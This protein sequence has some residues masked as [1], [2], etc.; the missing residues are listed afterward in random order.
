MRILSEQLELPIGIMEKEGFSDLFRGKNTSVSRLSIFCLKQLFEIF[1][2]DL[3]RPLRH[4]PNYVRWAGEINVGELQAIGLVFEHSVE[5]TVEKDPLPYNLAHA[6]IPQKLSR[7][8]S[9]VI[10]KSLIIHDEDNI[11]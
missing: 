6:T 4:P 9:R 5:I 7:G 1:H 11:E 3:D 2:R 8:L 10:I